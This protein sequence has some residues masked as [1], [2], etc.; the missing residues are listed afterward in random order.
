MSIPPAEL[1][2]QRTK[3][4]QVHVEPEI[5]VLLRV[6]RT[7]TGSWAEAEDL[8]QECLIRAWSAADRFDG[9]HPRAWLLTILRHTHLNMHRRRR[10]DTVEDVSLLPGAR[11]AFSP[12]PDLTPEEQVMSGVLPAGLE[13][14]VAG[15]DEKFRTAVL[16]VDVDGLTYAEAAGILDVPVGTVMSRLSRGRQRLRA[17]LRETMNE[18]GSAR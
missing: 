1:H 10:P 18:E 13:R 2:L 11:P 5:N 17:H 16:L 9:A 4:F 12:I 8:T 15:L 7:L 14:A 3:A 6:A